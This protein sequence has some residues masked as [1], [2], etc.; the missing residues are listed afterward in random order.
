MTLI[1]RTRPI[2]WHLL[3][4]ALLILVPQVALGLALGSWY[5][6]SE[7]HRVEDAAGSVAAAVRSQLDRELEAMK[8]ALQAL[9]TSP[10]VEA[11][12][13]A[14][15]RGQA[16]E[17]LKFRGTAI[18]ARDRSHQQVLNTFAAPD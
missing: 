10:N 11:G 1:P 7:R 9:A 12:D 14:A 16:T 5:A 4:F 8:A 17:L 15:L 13:F 6:T 2:R 3:V 18:A